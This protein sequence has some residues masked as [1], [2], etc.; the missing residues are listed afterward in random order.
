[1]NVVSRVTVRHLKEN[2]KRTVV[3]ILGI[4]L[5]VALITAISA[6]AE[7]FLD[8]MRQGEIAQGGEWHV[9]FFDMEASRLPE[10]TGDGNVKKTLVSRDL[11]NALL[12][13][14]ENEWKPYLLVKAYDQAAMEEYPTTLL[15]GR[16]PEK[17]GELAVP[18]HVIEDG[19]MDW[20]VGDTLT[21]ELGTRKNRE[22]E[23]AD[24]YGYEPEEFLSDTHEETYTIVGIIERPVFES[25]SSPS[26]TALTFLD[27]D[28]LSGTDTVNAAVQ[29]KHLDNSLFSWGDEKAKE[30]GAEHGYNSGLLSYYMLSGNNAIVSMLNNIKWVMM[31]IVA[32]GSVAVIY[33]SFAISISE[34]GRY[35]GMLASVGATRKQKRRSVF[36]EALI[37][38]GIGIPLGLLLGFAGVFVTTQFI[39]GLVADMVG[40]VYADVAMRVIISWRGVLGAVLLAA[41]TIF[42]SAWIPARRAAR[43]SPVEAIRQNKDIKLT[44][45][46]VKT[47]WLTRKLFGFE[48]ELALKNLKRNKKRYRATVLSLIFC[49]ALYLSVASFTAYLRGAYTMQLGLDG[50]SLPDVE[51]SVYTGAD[52]EDAME[53]AREVASLEHIS[54]AV[55]HEDTNI[56]WFPDKL[57]GFSDYVREEIESW[58]PYEDEGTA[59][60]TWPLYVMVVGLDDRSLEQYAK[61]AGADLETVQD[62]GVILVNRYMEEKDGRR[63]WKELWSVSA[64]DVLTG[65]Y[66][67]YDGEELKL[68]PL[69][70]TVAGSTDALPVGGVYSGDINTFYMYTTMDKALELMEASYGGD[71]EPSPTV[72]IKAEDYDA[73]MED[74]WDMAEKESDMSVYSIYDEIRTIDNMLLLINVFVYGFIILTA[75]I[76]VTSIFNTI[77]TSMALRRREYAMLKSV[78]MAPRRF[79]RMIAYESLF[80]GLK[81]LLYG[82]PIGLVLMYV[83]YRSIADAIDTGFYILWGQVGIAVVSVLLVVGL[84]MWYSSRKIKKANIVDVLKNENI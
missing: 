17:P 42:V 22:G 44:A 14:V 41:A 69:S 15:E 2:K 66:Q 18:E 64:G 1:M 62:G 49:I 78:G 51:V 53:R 60:E 61:Q 4:M 11:G 59:M 35:L 12:D 31:L 27:T 3:T 84:A 5:S 32:A 37:L 34:R 28:A 63:S 36:T 50:V 45:R 7:S 81:A 70:L 52:G 23:P 24:Y 79:N 47:G 20:S 13:P 58:G 9:E 83:I 30:L 71:A 82:L 67:S 77:S 29:V 33:S 54:E 55:I 72:S 75:L 38:G 10:L 73:L 8:M 56:V 76:C 39:K 19:G 26:Y 57:D 74:I 48:G 43:I 65:Q 16:Y 25:Y 46:Q 80:Y 68:E 21:L 40:D 6:F